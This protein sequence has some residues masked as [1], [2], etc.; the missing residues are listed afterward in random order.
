MK[1]VSHFWTHVF[2]SLYRARVRVA[3]VY[4]FLWFLELCT[5]GTLSLRT[6]PLILFLVD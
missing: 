6:L 2:L 5:Q 1:L 4:S 3:D